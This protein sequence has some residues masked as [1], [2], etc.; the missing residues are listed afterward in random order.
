MALLATWDP[1]S[2]TP[3]RLSDD[4]F[5]PTVRRQAFII[6]KAPRCFLPHRCSRLCIEHVL[7]SI[8][9]CGR[10]QASQTDRWSIT[11]TPVAEPEP[12]AGADPAGA[13]PELGAKEARAAALKYGLPV[14]ARC[15]VQHDLLAKPI[16]VRVNEGELKVSE[17]RTA[18][19]VGAVAGGCRRFATPPTRGGTAPAAARTGAPGAVQVCH[20]RPDGLLRRLWR[21]DGRPAGALERR[22]GGRAALPLLRLVESLHWC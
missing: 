13:A 19:R 3:L 15:K 14:V 7:R 20:P 5:L 8:R 18:C 22:A 17:L 4:V 11:L 2:G 6:I 12:A 16:R 1:K 21:V 10:V 9:V